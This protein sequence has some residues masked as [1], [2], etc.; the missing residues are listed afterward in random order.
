MFFR[1][2]SVYSVVSWLK[3]LRRRGYR[4]YITCFGILPF[5]MPATN[6]CRIEIQ[7]QKSEHPLLQKSPTCKSEFFFVFLG[8][9][10]PLD[11]RFRR[12]APPHIRPFRPH[13][14]FF[15]ENSHFGECLG[16]IARGRLVLPPHIRQFPPRTDIIR[17]IPR[18]TAAVVPVIDISANVG[19]PPACTM[20]KA[21]QI[22]TGVFA[23]A[24][25]R[26]PG[27]RQLR[28]KPDAN[29]TCAEGYSGE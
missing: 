20:Q 16:R 28:G 11:Q 22:E 8:K 21:T 23:G 6:R 1:S 24:Y 13:C 17:Q 18:Q 4:C 25:L 2:H 9:T 7:T 15:A 27:Q 3:H 14:I 12:I 19:R 26:A 5:Y 10:I 29:S